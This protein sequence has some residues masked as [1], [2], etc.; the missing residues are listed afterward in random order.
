MAWTN[1]P[2]SRIT[3]GLFSGSAP[4]ATVSVAAADLLLFRYKLLA[5]DTIVVDFRIGKAFFSPSNAAV[6]GI[7]MKLDIPFSSVHFPALGSPSSFND[8][9]Q[10]YSNDCIIALDPGGIPHAAGCV[11]LLNDSTHKIILLVRNVSGD[12][13]NSVGVVGAFGQVTFEM[14]RRKRLPLKRGKAGR[15]RRPSPGRR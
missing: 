2:L 13:I 10:S 6:S 14:T 11:A 4:G 5:R 12:N 1:V 15:T 9:G 3:F 7:T 8:G